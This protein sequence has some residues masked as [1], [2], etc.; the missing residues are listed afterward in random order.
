MRQRRFRASA[1][2]ISDQVLL[3]PGRI[4]AQYGDGGSLVLDKAVGYREPRRAPKPSSS[5]RRARSRPATISAMVFSVA[6]RLPRGH[7]E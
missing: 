3:P 1:D 2:R 4:A 5:C 7:L 6:S